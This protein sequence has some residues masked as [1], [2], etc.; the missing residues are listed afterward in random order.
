MQTTIE[1]LWPVRYRGIVISTC[2]RL[3]LRARLVA[4][5]FTGFILESKAVTIDFNDEGR[6]LDCAQ[7]EGAFRRMSGSPVWLKL[8]LF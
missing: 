7:M 5:D 8:A 2:F 4:P 6:T 3:P 1:E